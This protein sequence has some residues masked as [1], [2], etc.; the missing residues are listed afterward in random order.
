[1]LKSIISLSLVD[2]LTSDETRTRRKGNEIPR[3]DA[4]KSI[5]LRCHHMQPFGMNNLTARSCLGKSRAVTIAVN[6]QKRASSKSIIRL[7]RRRCVSNERRY[8]SRGR[9]LIRRIHNTRTMRVVKSRNMSK[10][11][12]I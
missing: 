8:T 6:R 4:G 11:R 3:A 10:R 5:N 2:P 1:M 12:N 9:W 7:S